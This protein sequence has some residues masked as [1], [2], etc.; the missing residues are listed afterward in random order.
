MKIEINVAADIGPVVKLVRKAQ[1][2]RQDDAAGSIGVSENFLAKAERGGQTAQW[3]KLFRVFDELGI[4]LL[5]DVPDHLASA[6]EIAKLL[7]V[8]QTKP[9]SGTAASRKPRLRS[10]GQTT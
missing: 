2:L 5:L 7:H 8:A 4:R 3:G 10:K 9:K 1:K 6:S